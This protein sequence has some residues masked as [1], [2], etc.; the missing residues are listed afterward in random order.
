MNAKSC[1][2]LFACFLALCLVGCKSEQKTAQGPLPPV[3]E[4]KQVYPAPQEQRP[5]D[6]E[7]RVVQK[8]AATQPSTQSVYFGSD[9]YRITPQ[10][11]ES[12]KKDA[13]LLKQN[14]TMKVEISGNADTRANAQYN[15]KLAQK[16]ADAVKQQLVKQGVNPEQLQVKSYGE[17][18]P[19]CGENTENCHASNRRVD[20]KAIG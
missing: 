13:E 7:R 12:L 6:V 10:A 16:R 4:A 9:K 5:T 14:P 3:S 1:L 11:A 20:L 17:A 2:V 19:V 15:Q 18:R 8:P